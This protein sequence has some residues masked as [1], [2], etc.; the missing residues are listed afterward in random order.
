MSAA[1]SSDSPHSKT[2]WSL[3]SR[4]SNQDLQKQSASDKS[5]PRIKSS[6]LKVIATAMGFKSKKT[7]VS[8]A[9]NSPHLPRISPRPN[10]DDVDFDRSSSSTRTRVDSLEPRT[11]LDGQR[12]GRQSLFTL[13]DIDPFATRGLSSP[14]SPTHLSVYSNPSNYDLH[15]EPLPIFRRV[16][17][18]SSHSHR[19][20]SELSPSDVA[21]HKLQPRSIPIPL[22]IPLADLLGR[23]RVGSLHRKQPQ[24]THIGSPEMLLEYIDNVPKPTPFAT[25]HDKTR[26][27]QPDLSQTPRLHVRPRGMTDSGLKQRP[28]FLS[29]DATPFKAST[30]SSPRVTTRQPSIPRISTPPTAPPELDL[31]L[32]PHQNRSHNPTVTGLISAF[33][34]SSCS[35]FMSSGCSKELCCNPPHGSRQMDNK[36][37]N[38]SKDV[39]PKSLQTQPASRSLK[40]AISQ[41]SLAKHTN[42]PISP[43]PTTFDKLPRNRRTFHPPKLSVPL[44]SRNTNACTSSIAT[45]DSSSIAEQRRGSAGLISLP[46]RKRLF[47]GSS[48]YCPSTSHS[49]LSDEDTRS[50]FSLRSDSHQ[51]VASSI[52]KPWIRPVSPSP[53][54]TSAVS[55]WQ[56]TSSEHLPSSPSLIT[57]Y[58]PQP[59]LSPDE[60]AELEASVEE[61]HPPSIPDGDDEPLFGDISLRT[62]SLKSR[63]DDRPTTSSSLTDGSFF[64]P[65]TSYP[66]MTVPFMIGSTLS[67]LSLPQVMMTSLPPPPRQPRFGPIFVTSP[68]MGDDSCGKISLP[69]PPRQHLTTKL[70]VDK[71]LQ[72][73]SVMRKPSFLE[74]D[75]D[76]EYGDTDVEDSGDNMGGSFLD[77]ARESFDTTRHE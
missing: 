11:P 64:S 38:G 48:S 43:S 36:K 55:P 7:P 66:N 67:N 51:T 15:A 54:P 60:M 33:A 74:I 1:L 56:E 47:S 70:S 57:E 77:L 19:R 41:Q 16:S 22:A 62:P 61:S 3:P 39:S 35:S 2:W 71:A 9:Q 52:F 10:V 72:R 59:I 37:P 53:S 8:P 63:S 6:G 58:I 75:D 24:T 40:K 12:E 68:R 73:R 32:P 27:N 5:S 30:L 50:V 76:S 34:S 14:L 26:S 69:P 31:P 45:N 13:S 17:Y 42:S 65:S 23:K 28:R 25:L 18:A 29:N 4:R 21:P 49:I 46:G 20:N 44:P